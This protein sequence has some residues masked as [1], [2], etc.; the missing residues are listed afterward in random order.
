LIFELLFHLLLYHL[1]LW[2]HSEILRRVFGQSWLNFYPRDLLCSML[3]P[4]NSRKRSNFY[5][6]SEEFLGTRSS[7]ILVV[8]SRLRK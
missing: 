2:K 1:R 7:R 4:I 8:S 3:D 5:P 6:C